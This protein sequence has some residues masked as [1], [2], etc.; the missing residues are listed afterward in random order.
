[1]ALDVIYH[2]AHE[3][4]QGWFDQRI[5]KV[6][7]QLNPARVRVTIDFDHSHPGQSRLRAE[8][9]TT[10]GWTEVHTVAGESQEGRELPYKHDRQ[11]D[12]VDSFSIDMLRTAMHI[13]TGTAAAV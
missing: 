1:M 9:W 11:P 12:Q 10:N 13:I 2:E 8:L 3:A 6:G 7:N 4:R 5:Y